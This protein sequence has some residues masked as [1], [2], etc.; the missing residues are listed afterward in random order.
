M[1]AVGLPE[2]PA[3]VSN[4]L[5]YRVFKA[6]GTAVL[7]PSFRS[8]ANAPKNLADPTAIIDIGRGGHLRPP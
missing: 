3:P 5:M 4:G 1:I 7:C 8:G 6:G 2:S